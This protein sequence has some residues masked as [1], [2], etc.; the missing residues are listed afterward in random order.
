MGSTRP[1][2]EPVERIVAT[3]NRPRQMTVA[4]PAA[5]GGALRLDAMLAQ[6]P[7]KGLAVDTRR[8]RGLRDV[9][10]VTVQEMGQVLFREGLEPGLARLRQRQVS[11]EQRSR[12]SPPSPD[13]PRQGSDLDDRPVRKGTGALDD[14]LKLA[15]MAGPVVCLEDRTSGG[16][17][18]LSIA[19]LGW[20]RPGRG[21]GASPPVPLSRPPF[22]Q[23]SSAT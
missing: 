15:D 8:L 5:P 6:E 22:R 19:A 16:D 3:G 13:V 1:A 11:L 10:T 12:R 9:A 17:G 4:P 2:T 23:V 21:D 20:L 14:I 18:D 7:V